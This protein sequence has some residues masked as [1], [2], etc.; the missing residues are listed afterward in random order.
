[1]GLSERHNF[2][3][4]TRVVDFGRYARGELPPP[5]PLAPGHEPSPEF[6][7][8]L[9]ARAWHDPSDFAWVSG[10]EAAS[11]TIRAELDAVLASNTASFAG[12]SVLQSEVMGAGWSALRLQRFGQWNEENRARFPE[13]A[14]VLKSLGIPTAIRGVMF[15]RQQAGSRVGYH[16]D[17]RNFVLTCHLGLRVPIGGEADEPTCW[18]EVGGERRGWHE[19]KCL[20]VDT[21]F[22]HETAN[23]GPTATSYIIPYGQPSN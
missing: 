20:V 5:S 23:S 3:D 22:G 14:A 9:D 19:G 11:G 10:L 21:S 4:I 2:K 13:T 16:S 18:I 6:V 7:D 1:M 12:D 8:G 17:G 15:A